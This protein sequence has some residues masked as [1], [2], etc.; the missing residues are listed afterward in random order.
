MSYANPYDRP[1]AADIPHSVQPGTPR[2][3]DKLPGAPLVRTVEFEDD[4]VAE[5]RLD[6]RDAFVA[7]S[8][9]ETESA[10]RQQYIAIMSRLS[11]ANRLYAEVMPVDLAG[12]SMTDPYNDPRVRSR[13]ASFGAKKQ[14]DARKAMAITQLLPPKHTGWIK[15]T[16]DKSGPRLVATNTW[17]INMLQKF[18]DTP[19]AIQLKIELG[20]QYA[21]N[22]AA[23]AS[24]VASLVNRHIERAGT[25]Q[26][27]QALSG[28]GVQPDVAPGIAGGTMPNAVTSPA[29]QSTADLTL[30]LIGSML[31]GEAKTE[32]I[33]RELD[34]I[35]LARE[36][37]DQEA[38]E[39][40]LASD[41]EVHERR[42]AVHDEEIASVRSKRHQSD[43]LFKKQTEEYNEGKKKRMT[44]ELTS[45]IENAKDD[46][47][48]RVLCGRLDALQRIPTSTPVLL[49]TDSI[50]KP[51]RYQ[52]HVFD[53]NGTA[54]EYRQ[55]AGTSLMDVLFENRTTVRQWVNKAYPKNKIDEDGFK[56]LGREVS[57]AYHKHLNHGGARQPFKTGDAQSPWQYF[58]LDLMSP[59]LDSIIEDFVKSYEGISKKRKAPDSSSGPIDCFV[60]RHATS[61]VFGTPI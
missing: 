4:G 33:R 12:V 17:V 50:K 15:Y 28:T 23:P 25:V 9:G 20:E 1:K 43:L 16:G 56:A 61:V 24:H 8:P 32:M 58:V 37:R 48:H 36:R 5:I 53:T 7:A 27:A 13:I 39:R 34:M 44:E 57:K 41:Q 60:K 31:D 11:S 55:P 45:Q 42:M 46:E 18:C 35:R 2:V 3:Y 21:L 10:I 59:P 19:E 14:K 30:V 26:Q 38:H 49:H 22:D 47:T 51:V 54:L 29:P 52:Q 6:V 40:R